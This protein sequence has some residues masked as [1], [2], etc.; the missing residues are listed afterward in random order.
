MRRY[1]IWTAAIA[2]IVCVVWLAL[3]VSCEPAQRATFTLLEPWRALCRLVTPEA[4]QTPGNILLA[5]FSAFFGIA[6]YSIVSGAALAAI[7]AAAQRVW[8]RPTPSK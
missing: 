6:V 5:V 4:W 1:F 7:V 2:G 3:F 8:D